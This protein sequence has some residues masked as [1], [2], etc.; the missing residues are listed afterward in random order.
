MSKQCQ[1]CFATEKQKLLTCHKCFKQICKFC[2][3]T[4]DQS[5]VSCIRSQI[6]EELISE[7]LS[8][9]KAL[10]QDLLDL[11]DNTQNTQ[12]ELELLNDKFSNLENFLKSSSLSHLEKVNNL[13][14]SIEAAKKDV[15]PYST[16]DNLELVVEGIRKS[17]KEKKKNFLNLTDLV[18]AEE[19]NLQSLRK[20]E[21]LS[22]DRIN[23]LRILSTNCVPYEDIRGMVCESCSKAVKKRFKELIMS[24]NVGNE[25][26]IKSVISFNT[27]ESVKS[28]SVGSSKAS[29][30]R[31]RNGRSVKKQP[32]NDGCAC[33]VW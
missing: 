14:K 8:R 12:L 2:K 20:L 19:K 1:V 25:S 4:P 32:V 28:A 18:E 15:V 16:I 9:K 33:L 3:P 7:S 10:N 17:E 21:K 24:G 22:Q 31:V 26:I 13:E 29:E 6:R 23:E 27:A 30:M 5:C 11:M